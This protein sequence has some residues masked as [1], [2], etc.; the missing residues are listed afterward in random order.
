MSTYHA[1]IFTIES[2]PD[3]DT[4]HEW[5]DGCGGVG[6]YRRVTHLVG[7]V[8]TCP[9]WVSWLCDACTKDEHAIVE[10]YHSRTPDAEA[11]ATEAR[12]QLACS[13]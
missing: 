3:S 4:N 10:A 13:V 12:W 9:A 1:A 6:H 2:A 8:P 7:G 11:Y 5:C